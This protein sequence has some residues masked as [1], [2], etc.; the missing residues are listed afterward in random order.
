M[1]IHPKQKAI[2]ATKNYQVISHLMGLRECSSV[3][4]PSLMHQS[5]FILTKL[6]V[7]LSTLLGGK[8]V[9]LNTNLP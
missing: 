6:M 7:Q 8:G 1:K 5:Y 9:H 3:F 4:G 2:S